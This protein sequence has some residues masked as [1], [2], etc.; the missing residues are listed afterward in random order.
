MR[1]AYE[2][3]LPGSHFDVRGAVAR[4]AVAA[5]LGAALAFFVS[6]FLSIIAL[7]IL[8][9]LD[10]IKPDMTETYRQIAAPVAVTMLPVIFFANL[11]WEHRRFT[12][13]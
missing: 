9:W 5:A 10:G 3:R 12:R 4:S 6:M 8:G 1:T 2:L 11:F 7:V 13:T